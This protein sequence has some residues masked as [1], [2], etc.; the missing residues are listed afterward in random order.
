MSEKQIE[1]YEYHKEI[2]DKQNEEKDQI[3]KAIL[4][5]IEIIEKHQR[6]IRELSKKWLKIRLNE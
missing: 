4:N 1:A 5:R 6:A 3:M 2:F